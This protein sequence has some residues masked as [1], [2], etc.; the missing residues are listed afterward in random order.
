ME[1]IVCKNYEEISVKGAEIIAGQIKIKPD[2]VL[3][4]ATGNSP[5][6]IYDRLCMMHRVGALD[7]SKVKSFNLDEYLP[8]E[9]TDPNSYAAFMHKIF[10]RYTGGNE[11]EAAV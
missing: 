3:G 2:S 10:L 1:F 11:K 5:I 7:F 9:P 6:G 4:L 8:I